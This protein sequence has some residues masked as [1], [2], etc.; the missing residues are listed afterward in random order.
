MRHYK[1]LSENMIVAIG[2]GGTGGIEISEDEYNTLLA[3]I[4]A[5]A[6]EEEAEQVNPD[7]ISAE[8][9]LNIIL[10]GEA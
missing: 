8:E 5:K 3:E 7:E 9:A 6:E 10:G 1:M 2:T 4:K